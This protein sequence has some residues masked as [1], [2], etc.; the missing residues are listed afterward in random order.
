MC[1]L[2]FIWVRLYASEAC[3]ETSHLGH[4][5]SFTLVRVPAAIVFRPNRAH[6]RNL[7]ILTWR[8]N[9][10]R[11]TTCPTCRYEVV[12]DRHGVYGLQRNLLVEN[13]IDMYQTEGRKPTFKTSEVVMCDQHEE[14]KVNIYCVTC[15]KPTCSLCKVFGDHQTCNV[16]PMEKIY[17]EQKSEIS[18]SIALLVAGNDRLQAIISQTE[19]LGKMAECNGRKVKSDLCAAFDKLYAVL[20][21][22]K[23]DMMNRITSDV[24][25]RSQVI[26]E[27]LKSYGLQLESA[28]KLMEASLA[29]VE[30]RSVPVFL[31]QARETINKIKATSRDSEVRKPPFKIQDMDEFTVDFNNHETALYKLDFSALQVCDATTNDNNETNDDETANQS[32]GATSNTADNDDDSEEE[33]DVTVEDDVGDSDA[34]SVTSRSDVGSS[35]SGARSNNEATGRSQS[36]SSSRNNGSSS[37]ATESSEARRP[38]EERPVKRGRWYD[39]YVRQLP[40]T[41][42]MTE[43]TTLSNPTTVRSELELVVGSPK[44]DHEDAKMDDDDDC[45]VLKKKLEEDCDE[46]NE[47]CRQMSAMEAYRRGRHLTA[48]RYRSPEPPQTYRSLR[49]SSDES[50]GEVANIRLPLSFQT[51]PGESFD[52]SPRSSPI[53]RRQRNVQGTSPTRRRPRLYGSHRRRTWS[54]LLDKK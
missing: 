30:E 39:M 52:S 6:Y 26:K 3:H 44:K 25:E 47:D 15:Q 10:I 51:S 12:L 23:T 34:T 9:D 40:V 43:S 53:L 41:F 20:E 7:F 18:D 38:L 19:E 42:D 46:K 11:V 14:E 5:L 54:H 49:Y 16:S 29:L 17:K 50:D 37:G 31:T 8:G 2:Y 45:D 24:Q 27:M 48:N 33:Y 21:Q 32:E 36:P 1:T 13:I 22:R 28:S 4:S 35:Y